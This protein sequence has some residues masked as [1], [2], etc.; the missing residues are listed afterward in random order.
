M[1]EIIPNLYNVKEN[2]YLNDEFK[3]ENIR[4][5]KVKVYLQYSSLIIHKVENQF[6]NII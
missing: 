5:Y 1:F 2:S 6:V 3:Y 4:E